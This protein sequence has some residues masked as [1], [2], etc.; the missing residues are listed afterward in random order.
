[1]SQQSNL[2]RFKNYPKG[3]RLICQIEC[4][5]CKFV[6]TIILRLFSDKFHKCNQ[7][8]NEYF[9]GDKKRM[10]DIVFIIIKFE[11]QI[12]EQNITDRS[13]YIES[14]LANHVYKYNIS[15]NQTE[16]SHIETSNTTPNEN[17]DVNVMCK[18][19]YTV[20]L[21]YLQSMNNI[22]SSNSQESSPKYKFICKTCNFFT[23]KSCNYIEHIK[24]KK[25]KYNRDN[26]NNCI[27]TPVNVE[28]VQTT[29]TE[30]QETRKTYQCKICN[31]PYY[32]KKGLW[33]H[34]KQC[35]VTTTA[36]SQSNASTEDPSGLIATA[37]LMSEMFKS[38]HSFMLQLIN[39]KLTEQAND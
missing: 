36:P 9:E 11:Q 17:N 1:M 4:I 7:Y 19:N 12:L 31:K 29:T 25:H 3:S 5:D 20:L 8:G 21:S 24:T 26:S 14:I 28:G 27:H 34:S 2:S 10:I 35:K 16:H 6:E 23:N 18:D 13:E 15:N 22:L 39:N 38:N 33:Q 37:T 30:I 32:S